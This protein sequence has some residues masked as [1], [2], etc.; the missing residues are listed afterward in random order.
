MRTKPN[1]NHRGHMFV[2]TLFS[3][4]SALALAIFIVHWVSYRALW[5]DG[6]AI[7]EVDHVLYVL[8]C[9]VLFMAASLYPGIGLNPAMEMKAVTQLATI[10]LLIVIIFL[11]IT[12]PF[13]RQAKIDIILIYLFSIFMVLGIRWAGRILAA[14]FGLWGEPVVVVARDEKMETM[15]R[16]FL[17]RRRLGFVPV[18]GVT[19]ESNAPS[20]FPINTMGADEFSR[21]PDH[22][23][24]QAGINTVLIDSLAVGETVNINLN[25]KFLKKFKHVIFVSDM[26]WLEGVSISYHDFEGM[27]GIEARQNFLS[28][29][30]IF[31]K[32]VMD[33]LLSSVI[34]ILSLPILLLTAVLIRLESPG[35]IFYRQ[36]RIGRNGR[37]ILVQKFRSMQV[38]ADQILIEYLANNPQARVE[39]E[40]NQKLR[41]DPRITRVGKWIRKFSVDEMPQ[42]FNILKG[43]MSLV[44]PRP[45]VEGEVSRYKDNFDVYSTVRPG[46]TG[47]WQV[48]GRNHTS[49]E[50]RVL[51]DVYYVRNWSVWLDIYI[52]LRT[53]WVVLSRDGAY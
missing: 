5:F 43:E 45:I 31:L 27:I 6:S 49:Y 12:A 7:S 51:Y 22:Y 9:L 19:F 3:D 15:M 35:P 21:L 32:R 30:D 25:R 33:I 11:T 50:E 28:P 47:M 40:E 48:S 17:Q 53:V 46:V 10:S 13:W 16:Y 14:H 41:N 1:I 52:L 26:D 29:L 37:R 36:E 39:W 8:I 34:L 42:L 44:G 18:L 2:I 4:L 38:G 24:G 23:F 20:T